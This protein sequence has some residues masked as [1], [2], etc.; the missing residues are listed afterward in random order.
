M[1]REHFL[2]T[3]RGLAAAA[4][5]VLAISCSQGPAATSTSSPSDATATP[6]ESTAPES[7]VPTPRTTPPGTPAPTPNEPN[8]AAS[9]IELESIP[10]A[11]TPTASPQAGLW[12]IQ[13]YVVDEDGNPLPG[14][15]VVVGPLGCK[16]FSPHT[17][18]R[19]HWFLDIA[20]EKNTTFDFFFEMPG[21]ST[22]WWRVTPDAPIEFNVALPRG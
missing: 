21:R 15:C 6:G 2:M 18:D 7:P 9:S 12:R 22:I 14:V 1:T 20:A 13:G 4:L 16:P 5:I 3:G 8:A 17:D 10:P 19:G 11:A